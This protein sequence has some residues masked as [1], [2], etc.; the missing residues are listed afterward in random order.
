MNDDDDLLAAEWALGLLDGA[1][2]AAAAVRIAAEP[3]LRERAEWWGAQFAGLADGSSEA[4]R[5]VVWSR[6]AEALPQNDNS[7]PLVQRWRSTALALMVLTVGLASFILLRPVPAPAPA[8]QAQNILLASLASEQG[9]SATIAY[10]PA[11]GTL[12][13]APAALDVGSG[14]AELWIIPAD[15]TPR[16]LGVIDARAAATHI[17]AP[18][19]RGLI[20][21]GT[22]FA[23]SR[24]TRGGSPTGKPTGPIIG[25]GKII[26]T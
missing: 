5:D 25:S 1:D 24:E 4:P 17:V 23:I 9:V 26:A 7:A 14:D 19:Q 3:A 20:A 2:A 10:D 12:A 22:S 13:I 18:A 21:P 8:P 16:S 6:I 11:R 15:G